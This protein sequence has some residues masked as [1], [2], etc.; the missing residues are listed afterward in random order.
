MADD[1][2]TSLLLRRAALVV[3]VALVAYLSGVFSAALRTFPYPQTLAGPFKALKAYQSRSEMLDSVLTSDLWVENRYGDRK[4]VVTH[5]PD[6]SYEGYTFY[7]THNTGATLVD[8][9]G[10]IVHEWHT[11]FED[12]WPNPP[13]VE[14]PSPE[15]YVFWRRAELLPDGDVLAIYTT[16]ADS[17]YGYGLARV[18]RNSELVWKFSDHAHHDFD[19][20]DDGSVYTIT[21]DFR[22]LRRDPLGAFPQFPSSI[23]K[24]DLVKISPDGEEVDRMSILEALA[25]SPYRE[26]VEMFDAR[27]KNPASGETPWD[28]LHTNT[29]DV[30]GPDFAEHHEFAEAGQVM[31]SF[32]GFDA[33]ALAD[34]QDREIVWVGR[35]FWA[36]QHD[37]DP[38]PNGNI[39]LFDNKGHGGPGGPSRVLEYDPATHAVVWSYA[40]SRDKPLWSDRRASQ[41]PLANGNVLITS[42]Q[43]GRLLEVTRDG[44]IAW[45]FINP[46]R[47]DHDGESYI[48]AV[49]SGQRITREEL[50]FDPTEAGTDE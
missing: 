43:G 41:Q 40:G 49:C 6:Q 30:I 23:L 44:E 38:L 27:T 24:D 7:T 9:D 5:D 19:L 50:D 33:L 42:S 14:R 48:A 31:L 11:P 36:E 34:M 2:S 37:P 26:L 46:E 39:L 13:H 18:D 4:G 20:Q 45:E 28:P 3:A 25:D 10:E 47:R 16:T 22:N 29:V 17:P 35:G 15:K 12:V 8:P 32:R 21:H 1:S